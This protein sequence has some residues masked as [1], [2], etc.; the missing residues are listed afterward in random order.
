MD[1]KVYGKI[2]NCIVLEYKQILLFY[3]EEFTNTYVSQ[4]YKAKP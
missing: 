1:G 4:N 3:T 2:V